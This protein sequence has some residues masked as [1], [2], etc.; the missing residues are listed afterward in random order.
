MAFDTFDEG[1]L[2]GGLR[3]KN[4]I[5]ILICYLFNSVKENIDK[6]IVINSILNESLANYFEASSAFDELVLNGSL[7]EQQNSIGESGFV[8]TDKGKMIANQL[9]TNLAY[10]VKEKAYRCATKLLAQKKI[11]RENKVEINKIDNGYNVVF[12]ISGGS[13]DLLKFT[14]YAPSYEQAQMMKNNF[15]EYPSTVYSVMLALVTKDKDSVGAALEEIYGI[16]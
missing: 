6:E 14:L 13:T 16:F 8:L 12:T 9:E 11:E 1:I 3:S 15:Y 10:T 5:K 4:E 2:P 7:E